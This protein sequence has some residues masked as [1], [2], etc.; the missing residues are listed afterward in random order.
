MLA[1]AIGL[2]RLAIFDET[3]PGVG[4]GCNSSVEVDMG[5]N[6]CH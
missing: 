1:I 3:D 2:W 5:G 6:E 4:Q